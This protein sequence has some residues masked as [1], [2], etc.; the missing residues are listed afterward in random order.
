MIG[1]ICA[2]DAEVE[3]II[4]EMK[5]REKYKYARLTYHVGEIHG[6]Y[7]VAAECGVGKV[8]AA[9][10]TQIMIDRFSPDVIINSGIAG[11][12][13]EGIKI[14]DIVISKDCVQHD[15]DGTEMG[16]PPGLIY[17]NDEKLIS[18]PAD[19]DIVEKLYQA[20]E[21]LDNTK[22][23]TGRIASGDS[24]IANHE[25]RQKIAYMFDSIACEM[26]GGAVAQVCYRNGIPYAILR[27]ISD[28]FSMKES[29]D[30]FTFRN[31][32]A[33]KSVKVIRRF[34]EIL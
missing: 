10:S 17:F 28:D 4:S 11:S 14:G 5:N 34:L 31:I 24:F 6:Q 27:C 7:V 21:I 15:Y 8:N 26:E 32:A 2:L 16:D 23:L 9:M 13:S 18:I 20:C 3:G 25:R 22:I 19:K 29:I 12:L 30:Y 33:E 1:F